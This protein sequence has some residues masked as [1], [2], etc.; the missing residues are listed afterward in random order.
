VLASK[1]GEVYLIEYKWR[2]D[3]ANVDD[4]DSLNGFD[5]QGYPLELRTAAVSA[6]GAS[7]APGTSH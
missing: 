5:S 4:I 2:S 6:R 7:C 3:K 1:A